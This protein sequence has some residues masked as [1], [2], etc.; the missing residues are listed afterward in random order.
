MPLDLKNSGSYK[1]T[2]H[3]L[4]KFFLFLR[5]QEKEQ[6]SLF[7]KD[8]LTQAKRGKLIIIKNSTSTGKI[9]LK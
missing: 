8:L 7:V 4:R 6:K 5:H 3:R 1:A 9:I 2:K